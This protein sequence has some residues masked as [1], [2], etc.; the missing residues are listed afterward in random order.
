MIEKEFLIER[1]NRKE[2]TLLIHL[3]FD[4][5]ILCGST[6]CIFFRQICHSSGERWQRFDRRHWRPFQ[7]NTRIGS[8]SANLLS[9][10]RCLRLQHDRGFRTGLLAR[11]I[12]IDQFKLQ[13]QLFSLHLSLLF[14]RLDGC[15]EGRVGIT[16]LVDE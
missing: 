15:D 16:I 5:V 4:G 3:I 8:V 13:L 7:R 10:F 2:L 9:S 14:R 12:L 11:F 6:I 1:M